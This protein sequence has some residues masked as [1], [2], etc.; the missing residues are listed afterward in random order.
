M[1]SIFTRKHPHI[2][3]ESI[4]A[5]DEMQA[6][7]DTQEHEIEALR[8]QLKIL[9]ERFQEAKTHKDPDGGSSEATQQSYDTIYQKQRIEKLMS[10]VAEREKQMRELQQ[11]MQ[12][13]AASHQEVLQK[14]RKEKQ[15]SLTEVEALHSQLTAL[16]SKFQEGQKRQQAQEKEIVELRSEKEQADIKLQE[17][18][19]VAEQRDYLESEC[20]RMTQV[21]IDLTLR[22]EEASSRVLAL[23]AMVK[24]KEELLQAKDVHLVN[25]GASLEETERKLQVVQNE[26]N[27]LQDNIF[28]TQSAQ[29]DAEARLKV[30]HFHL[31]KKVKENAQLTDRNEELESQVRE[32][33]TDIEDSQSKIQE[34]QRMLEEQ[35]HHERKRQEQLQESVKEAEALAQAWEEKYFK[36]SEKWQEYDVRFTEMKKLEEKLHKLH[37]QWINMGFLLDGLEHTEKAAEA[38]EKVYCLEKNLDFGAPAEHPLCDVKQAHHTLFDHGQT[39]KLFKQ[40]RLE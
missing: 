29:E 19:R 32:F 26:R 38:G 2:R 34:L 37:S 21:Q 20:E 31:A 36:I 17:A 7:I 9:K 18:V 22:L 16:K 12:T 3:H 23:E 11:E 14:E 30:A 13:A 4:I 40:H 6:T 8:Q 33:T 10:V 35:F 1:T 28:R 39:S 5:A 15:I 25:V 24:S 27:S